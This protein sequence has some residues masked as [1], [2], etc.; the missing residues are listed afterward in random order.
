MLTVVL[1]ALLAAPLPAAAAPRQGPDQPAE[2]ANRELPPPPVDTSERPPPGQPS[3]APLPVPETPVGGERMG[4]CGLVLP[5]GAPRP[6]EELTAASWVVQDLETG[7]IL[8]AKDPH[9]RQRPASLVKSLLALVVLRDLE[10]GQVVVP[11]ELDASQECT[12]VG[13]VP[14]GRYT[15]DQ[16]LHALL[17]RSG[18]DV[19]HA[20]ATALGGV[21]EALR[22]MNTL[23]ARLGAKD[24]RAASP[25]GLDGPGMSSSAYDMGLVFHHAMRQPEYAAAVATRTMEF[26]GWGDKPAFPIYND[27]KLLGSYPGF[28]GGKTG[29]TDDSRHT[30]A[31]AAER[32]GRRLA[33][34]MLRGEQRPTRLTDQAAALLDYGFALAAAG[35]P[36]VGRIDYSPTALTAPTAEPEPAG[37]GGTAL[38][39]ATEDPFGTTGWI[40][41]IVVSVLSVGMVITLHR[42]RQAAQS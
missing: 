17:M 14:G 16:L 28:L 6:P 18:N 37:T 22:R 3:P 35:T 2:C 13:I 20:L 21:P 12:C 19:A 39:T 11:T 33:V 26:P 34:V 23:A 40:I 30:Y 41:T 15:V 36:P 24:T 8:A 9:G 32:N 10:P 31:G 1:S 5:P 38:A 29:F 27:N 4:E 25:S 42:R 7:A